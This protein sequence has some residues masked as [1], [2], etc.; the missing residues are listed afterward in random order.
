[1][2]RILP[3]L[4]AVLLCQPSKAQTDTTETHLYEMYQQLNI[5]N[6]L[7]TTLDFEY[8]DTLKAS[9]VIGDAIEGMLG[10]LDPYTEYYPEENTDELRQLT[11]GK[12]AGIGSIIATDRKRHRCYIADPYKGMPAERAGLHFGDI[13]MAQDGV[14][15]GLATVGKEQEYST[16][17]SQSLRGEPGTSFDLTV[18]RPGIEEPLTFH[19]TR[20]Q[21]QLPSVT[22]SGMVSDT[23]GY[24]LLSSY[25][26]NT[27]REVVAAIQ[28]LKQRGAR[29]LVLDLR[30]NPGGLLEQAVRITGL[31]IPKGKEVVRLKGKVYE[32][33]TVYKT[34][35]EPIEPTIPLCVM[36]SN[37]TASAAEI[38][39]GAL[40]D[41]DRAVIVGQRT[42]GKGLVQSPRPM[43]SGGVLKMTTAKYYIPSGRCIQA[44]T[45][46]NGEPRH[47]PDS[48]A[49]AF[50][51]AGGRIVYDGGGIKPDIELQP[52]SL[53][54]LLS[55]LSVSD[56]LTE[57]LVAYRNSHESIA[58]PEAFSLTDAEYEELKDFL[59]IHGFTYDNQSKAALDVLRRIAKAEGYADA[60]AQELDELE[61]KLSP[62]FD[63]DFD[64]WK[65][66][67]KE[68]VGARIVGLYHYNEGMA[69][70]S[71]R[72][73]KELKAAI[74]ALQ[75]YNLN[76]R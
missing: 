3:L 72:S 45:Y 39:S 52:D 53:P 44:Y 43:P 40:Q 32:Q 14:D 36:V 4:L 51:T 24:V 5:F 42:Y 75:S 62:G 20:Q 73:D 55:Y 60:A 57:Y 70:Y 35:E 15:Y 2:K 19:I 33:A 31:F 27:T 28:G 59:R 38:T 37:G 68:Y 46:A 74:E 6:N 69:A 29:A 11:T 30:G 25:T 71:L 64:H 66:E 41:Y 17:V 76:S 23:I 21:I 61:K 34:T 58:S 65:A 56:V 50:K 47:L 49:K 7:Y 12:Y 8:V 13:I 67:V 18:I 9:K 1:M 16:R 54:T 10:Q 48:I 26:E 22:Y 63:Y